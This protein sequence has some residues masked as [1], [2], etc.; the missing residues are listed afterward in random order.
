LIPE[1]G[2]GQPEDIARTVAA[3]ATGE[4]PFATGAV[5]E[6]SGGMNIRHL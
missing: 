4:I 1:G 6:I 2:W 3:L 5:I